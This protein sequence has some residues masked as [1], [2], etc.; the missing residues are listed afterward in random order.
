MYF[1][2]AIPVEITFSNNLLYQENLILTS[3]FILFLIMDYFMKM[4]TIYY[5][6]GKP[7]TD[8]ILVLQNYIKNGF[9]IDGISILVI[10]LGYFN[11]YL[12]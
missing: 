7:V 12:I 11:S 5:E 1:F 9:F 6:F 10:V 8:R 3:A 2:I 4:N